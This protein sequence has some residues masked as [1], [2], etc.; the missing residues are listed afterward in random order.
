MMTP[1]QIKARMAENGFKPS[2]ANPEHRVAH[3]LEYIAFYLE[4]IDV[5]LNRI[6]DSAH[7]LAKK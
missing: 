4:R 7:V 1:E 2:D 5:S 6:A 3:A